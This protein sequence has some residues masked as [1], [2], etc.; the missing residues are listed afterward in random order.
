M[1]LQASFL[2]CVASLSPKMHPNLILDLIFTFTL[3]SSL[4]IISL[5]DTAPS[6]SLALWKVSRARADL[7]QLRENRI[8]GPVANNGGSEIVRLLRPAPLQPNASAMATAAASTSSAGSVEAG[9]PA[10]VGE[11]AAAIGGS[12]W[13]VRVLTV[14]FSF[15]ESASL[16]TQFLLNFCP[17]PFYCREGCRACRWWLRVEVKCYLS[18]TGPR[19]K[20]EESF[21]G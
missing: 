4:H 15:S 2:K 1:F 9:V 14:M 20:I 13:Q 8:L 17:S 10:A 7:I 18:S 6:P 3:T 16:S 5:Y 12:T 19:E 21:K 11:T